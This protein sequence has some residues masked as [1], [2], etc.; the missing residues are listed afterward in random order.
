MAIWQCFVPLLSLN[1]HLNFSNALITK[2]P[3]EIV[4][5]TTRR[6]VAPVTNIVGGA[7]RADDV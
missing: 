5:P 1:Y 3:T 4:D 2:L 7:W 6:A